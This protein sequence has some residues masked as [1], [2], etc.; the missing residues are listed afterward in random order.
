M[1]KTG[2]QE[3][4]TRPVA[5]PLLVLVLGG[6]AD[7]AKTIRRQA[8]PRGGPSRR[9]GRRARPVQLAQVDAPPGVTQ[10]GQAG[11]IELLP[12]RRSTGVTMWLTSHLGPVM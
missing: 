10:T 6:G 3:L 1:R 7:A 9:Q 4:R 5:W 12:G 11:A 8:A 2:V